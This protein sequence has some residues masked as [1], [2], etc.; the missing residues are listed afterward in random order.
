[1]YMWHHP[2]VDDCKEVAS[3]KENFGVYE[4]G[5]FLIGPAFSVP[6][7]KS[8]V[9]DER[10]CTEL[11]MI[12]KPHY[13]HQFS[14][15]SETSFA[16]WLTSVMAQWVNCTQ[17]GKH[18]HSPWTIGVKTLDRVL[19]AYSG[20]EPGHEQFSLFSQWFCAVTWLRFTSQ[21]SQFW[22]ASSKDPLSLQPMPVMSVQLW[23][24]K[25]SI[26]FC[27]NTEII[28]VHQLVLVFL[29]HIK[30]LHPFIC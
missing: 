25:T 12:F 30:T 2:W 26:S 28:Q 15:L 18:T 7:Q 22:K 14:I 19:T 17:Q 1:M 23:P 9:T 8:S 3:N 10:K 20:C 5:P 6:S 21:D 4:L 27:L 16:S 11:S 13:S 24:V 29:S